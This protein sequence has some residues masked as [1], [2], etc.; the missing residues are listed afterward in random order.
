VGP[1]ATLIKPS[2]LAPFFVL[3]GLVHMAAVASRF[4]SLAAKLPSG[5]AL[6]IMFAQ[7]PLLYLS[8]YFES[9]CDHGDSP[10]SFP[11]WMR[12]DSKAVMFCFS[13]GFMY[14][15]I[16]AAQT[17]DVSFGPINPT[18]PKSFPEWQ[19]AAWF[20]M[21]TGGAF[22]LFYMA[23]GSLLIPVLRVLAWPLKFLPTIVAAI[24]A[25][26]IGAGVGL[27]VLAAVQSQKLGAYIK[28]IKTTLY[29]NP[30][31]FIA[32]TCVLTLGPLLLGVI[33]EKKQE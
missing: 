18:P 23:A 22:L 17:W 3:A 27:V 26:A 1:T 15:V 5:A 9:R 14:I 6:A 8:G 13:F 24:M 7:F 28:A 32:V 25:L 33:L 4:D 30:A 21:F 16:V 31:L 12:I 2:K 10:K 11:I 20:A 19:R 29:A